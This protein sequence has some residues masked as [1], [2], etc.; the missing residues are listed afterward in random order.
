MLTL[1]RLDHVHLPPSR[2]KGT[3]RA[4]DPKEDQLSDIPKV[5]AN[6]ASVGTSVLSSLGPNEVADI[7]EAPALHYLKALRE[8]R[9]RHPQVKVR[10]IG[11]HPRNGKRTDLLD[12]HGVV[13]VETAML[14]GHLSRAI[15]EAPRWISVDRSPATIDLRKRRD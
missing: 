4:A 15:H 12:R 14:W 8:K 5:E 9:I 11:N 13:A 10:L 6:S 3:H 1:P 7:P 2:S